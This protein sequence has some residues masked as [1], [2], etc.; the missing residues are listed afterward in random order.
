MDDVLRLL[1]QSGCGKVEGMRALID[2]EGMSPR[3][4]KVAVHLS[5][6]WSDRLVEDEA[7]HD[8]VEQALRDVSPPI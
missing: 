7:L 5:P 4:A 1:R 3:E 6:V 2:L 8:G